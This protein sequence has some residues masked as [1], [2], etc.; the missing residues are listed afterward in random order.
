MA[1]HEEELAPRAVPLHPGYCGGAPGS[2]RHGSVTP[3]RG[4][5][6]FIENMW[7][8]AME[9]APAP[10]AEPALPEQEARREA[11]WDD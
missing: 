4:A 9:S 1:R 11:P 5:G 7:R 2:C 10:T 8:E 6:R 3:R